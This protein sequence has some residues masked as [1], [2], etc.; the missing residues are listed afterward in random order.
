MKTEAAKIVRAGSSS[1]RRAGE[2]R[3]RLLG[4]SE[5]AIW[6]GLP[7]ARS[8]A[9]VRGAALAQQRFR[10]GGL[11]A[12]Q[13]PGDSATSARHRQAVSGVWKELDVRQ[14]DADK[15]SRGAGP[16]TSYSLA[17]LSLQSHNIKQQ[18]A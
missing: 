9:L 15:N 11:E 10:R 4:L 7:G 3:Q 12:K 18:R 13:L 1:S 5:P 6:E 14:N 16:A 2:I 17:S 8:R